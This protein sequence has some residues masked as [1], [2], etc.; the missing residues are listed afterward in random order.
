MSTLYHNIRSNY[1]RS[2]TSQKRV[3]G[4]SVPKLKKE[5]VEFDSGR[6]Q[7]LLIVVGTIVL[8]NVTVSFFFLIQ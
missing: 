3:A 5:T 2:H 6:L 8:Q 1:R 4:F 7:D